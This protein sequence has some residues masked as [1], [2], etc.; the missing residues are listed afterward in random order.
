MK[1]I[2]Y[3]DIRTA[4]TVAEFRENLKKY[5]LITTDTAN[6]AELVVRSNDVQ[7]VEIDKLDSLSDLFS[8]GVTHIVPT[9][10]INTDQ[11][12]Q[13]EIIKNMFTRD[14]SSVLNDSSRFPI[15]EMNNH[16]DRRDFLDYVDVMFYSVDNQILR[17]FYAK[18]LGKFSGYVSSEQKEVA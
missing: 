11:I 15:Y 5:F 13:Q 18:T 2:K 17:S 7:R 6:N 12:T 1:T 3:E 4:T 14:F 8:L 10:A 16:N 9:I